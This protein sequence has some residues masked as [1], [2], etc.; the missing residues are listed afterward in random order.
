V[1]KAP[2]QIPQGAREWIVK[3]GPW[4]TVVL[5]VLSLPPLLV[6]PGVG[7][8]LVPFG[9]VG[10][11]AGCGYMT[12]VLIIQPGLTVA[13]LPGLFARKMA[14]GTGR[15]APRRKTAP[16]GSD[17]GRSVNLASGRGA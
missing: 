13:A 4:I 3:Y 8:A 16:T 14:V 12:V 11:A 7:T 17:R 2:F 1:Q 6:V 9:G 15:A 5:L 10:Y